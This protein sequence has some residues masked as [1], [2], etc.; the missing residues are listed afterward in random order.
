LLK[1]GTTLLLLALSVSAHSQMYKW[2]DKDGRVHYSDTPP[3][4]AKDERRAGKPAA[5]R[6]SVG[7]PGAE[8]AELSGGRFHPE[9]EAAA[10]IVCGIALMEGRHCAS[11]LNRYCSLDELVKGV[12]GNRAIAF[13]KDPRT[14]PNYLYRVD[15][16]G[17][18]IAISADARKP[19]LAG[20]FSEGDGIRYNARGSA[21]KTDKPVRGGANC[22]GFTK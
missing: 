15:I 22:Q 21:G 6:T 17:T 3:P 2:P 5:P 20:F 11:P 14:D 18:D 8:K 16:R 1:N 10:S 9:E 19:G 12:D 13:K 4:G 7:A